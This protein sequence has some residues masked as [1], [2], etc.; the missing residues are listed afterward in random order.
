MQIF[1]Q[2][3]ELGGRKISPDEP[4]DFCCLYTPRYLF[5][6][7]RMIQV[8]GRITQVVKTDG[9]FQRSGRSNS[10][11]FLP[12]GWPSRSNGWI[13]FSNGW[14]S[15]SNGWTFLPNGWTSRSNGCKFFSNGFQTA[16]K[17]RNSVRKRK[18]V[19]V[20]FLWKVT[21]YYSHQTIAAYLP[22]DPDLEEHNSKHE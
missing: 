5:F 18:V 19:C 15:R 14:P 3:R 2:I 17:L 16:C 7:E 13:F 22:E 20:R 11:M 21:I 12:N 4:F 10:W 8:V 1:C 6:P 9:C